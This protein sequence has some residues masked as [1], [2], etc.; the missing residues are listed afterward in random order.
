MKCYPPIVFLEV[1][2]VGSVGVDPIVIGGVS[3]DGCMVGSQQGAI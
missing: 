3:C 2:V 1:G